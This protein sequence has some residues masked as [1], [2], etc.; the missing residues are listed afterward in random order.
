M[1]PVSLFIKPSNYNYLGRPLFLIWNHLFGLSELKVAKLRAIDCQLVRI[2]KVLS[3]KC[4]KLKHKKNWGQAFNLLYLTHMKHFGPLLKK[5]YSL[6]QLKL[7]IFLLLVLEVVAIVAWSSSQGFY[8]KAQKGYLVKDGTK[9]IIFWQN[10]QKEH[11][12]VALE[13]LQP[14]LK[15]AHDELELEVGS[16]P[17]DLHPLESLWLKANVSS[18]SIYWKT[19]DS[20]FLNRLTFASKDDAKVYQE[21]IQRGAYTPS[22]IGHSLALFPLKKN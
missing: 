11:G 9:F 7:P 8:P 17:L 22:P 18:Y 13:G 21:F 16:M 15:F 14:A 12:V 2:Q 4:L 19:L 3:S 10:D 20:A 1:V 6:K 5:K